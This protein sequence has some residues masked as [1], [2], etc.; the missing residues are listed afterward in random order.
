MAKFIL[1]EFGELKIVI[2][3]ESSVS[4]TELRVKLDNV[5]ASIT[6]LETKK[7]DFEGLLAELRSEKLRDEPE[8]RLSPGAMVEVEEPRP[9]PTVVKKRAKTK[10]SK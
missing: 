3:T 2:T 10:T 6:A 4:E 5:N 7:A 8:L 1:D 9:K